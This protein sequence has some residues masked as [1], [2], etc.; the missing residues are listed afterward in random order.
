M[1]YMDLPIG[2][3]GVCA[4]ITTIRKSG[5]KV[6][7]RGYAM[8]QESGAKLGPRHQWTC[9]QSVHSKKHEAQILANIIRDEYCGSQAKVDKTKRAPSAAGI[10]SDAY[11]NYLNLDIHNPKWN[12]NTEYK[13]CTYF[14][15]N[16]LPRLDAL[17]A[18][19]SS[20][21]L[22]EIKN[23]LVEMAVKSKNGNQN[24]NQAEKSVSQYLYR[25]NWILEQIYAC[26][27]SL[28]ELY[29][30]TVKATAVSVTEE[31]K[32]IPDRVRVCMA[33]ALMQTPA[34]G[35]SLGVAAMWQLGD[36]TAEACAI[37]IGDI[38]LRAEG[39]VVCKTFWQIQNGQRIPRLKTESAYR[40]TVGGYFMYCLVM[41]RIEY[42]HQ[43]GYI[44]EEILEMPLVSDPNDPRK[45]ADPSDLSSYAKALLLTCGYSQ[46]HFRLAASLSVREPLDVGGP[47]EKDVTAYILRRDWAGRASNV[48]GLSSADVD[49]L[50]GHKNP[51]T[52]ERDY[53]N[54]DVQKEI[55]QKLERYVFL[56]E[57]S[58]HPYFN[59][60]CP[61]QGMTVD[62][63]GYTAYRIRAAEGAIE[64]KLDIGTAECG[65]PITIWTNGTM[66]S[67]VEQ[68]SGAKDTPE[69]RRTRPLIGSI[70][71]DSYYQELKEVAGKVDISK[72]Q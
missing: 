63:E 2:V 40:Y 49:Y 48:C 7:L 6:V 1:S 60:I 22:A 29:F 17:G 5:G 70:H 55:A 24:P 41:A 8:D 18:D 64:V 20:E 36:R 72:F 30:D 28:R 9:N 33:Y 53:T 58:R 56:P 35:L 69:L 3:A 62:L 31:A 10:Y 34:N 44:D 57:Y 71:P 46:E 43:A 39:Y 42:L 47:P 50:I 51:A 66:K 19:L 4:H 26:T 45:Y 32:Y 11:L 23:D 21:D 37:K 68:R 52:K 15:R 67:P 65:E 16:I 12:P 54:P 38:I 14:E 27:P 25:V 59:P 61:E 13:A